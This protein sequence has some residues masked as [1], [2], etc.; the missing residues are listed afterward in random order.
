[1]DEGLEAVDQALT[2]SETSGEQSWNAELHRLRGELLGKT[3]VAAEREVEACFKRAME[4]ATADAAKAWELR[5][6]TSLARLWRDRGKAS[7]ARGLLA[8]VYGC[9]VEGLDT[10][11][12][13]D[14]KAVLDALP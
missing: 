14:A 4:I 1:M 12:L 8:P 7:E 5:A 6:A 11:D 2:F 13:V 10:P 3:A 9:F